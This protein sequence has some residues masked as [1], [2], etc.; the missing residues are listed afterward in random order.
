MTGFTRDSNGKEVLY[1]NFGNVEGKLNVDKESKTATFEA[2]STVFDNIDVNRDYLYVFGQ[3]DDYEALGKWDI[4]SY[5][6]SHTNTTLAL[7]EAFNG[8]NHENLGFALGHNYLIDP[9]SSASSEWQVKID[10]TDG[11]YQLDAEG[12]AF[13]TLKFPT[14]LIGKRTG[15]AVNF[16]GKTPETGKILRSGEVTFRTLHSFK[17]VITPDTISVDKNT[18]EHVRVYFDI[19]TGTVDIPPVLNSHVW[20]KTKVS[21]IV[22]SSIYEN[23]IV[24]TVE[25]FKLYGEYKAYWDLTLRASED[26]AGTFSFEECQVQSLPRF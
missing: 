22:S 5:E 7:S 13:V 16:L 21:N 9:G 26:Q 24:S 17:G 18:T 1:G 11:K 15:L 14:Y 2:S 6:S 3:I 4:D 23:T 12:K 8:E 20:C 25:E 19:D 10:S